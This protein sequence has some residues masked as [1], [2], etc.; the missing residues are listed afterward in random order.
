MFKQ[1][2]YA[3]LGT[4]MYHLK[5]MQSAN[6]LPGDPKLPLVTLSVEAEAQ[7]LESQAAIQNGG[8]HGTRYKHSVIFVLHPKGKA[9]QVK[10]ATGATGPSGILTS[11][12]MRQ[13]DKNS[14][15][16]LTKSIQA[17]I[18]D[19]HGA[20]GYGYVAARISSDYDPDFIAG[21]L[22]TLLLTKLGLLQTLGPLAPLPAERVCGITIL[23]KGVR[24]HFKAY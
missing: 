3:R 18:R 10:T 19:L 4:A 23:R 20:I 13:S 15:V 8:L 16:R 1:T 9:L 22:G 24:Y 11:S 21:Y 14:K 2:G 5:L 17:F 6:A 7:T 12:W